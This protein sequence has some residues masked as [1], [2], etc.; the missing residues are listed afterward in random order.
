MFRCKYGHEGDYIVFPAVPD[1]IQEMEMGIVVNWHGEMTNRWEDGV[2]GV[3][4]ELREFVEEET[5]AI[6]V[7][8]YL[9]N[10][11]FAFD[12]VHW[13]DDEDGTV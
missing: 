13:K 10:P 2:V 3:P 8:C 7:T 11:R 5:E 1:S 12:I 9:D 6:C 4:E